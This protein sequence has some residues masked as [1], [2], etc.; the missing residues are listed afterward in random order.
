MKQ[1]VSASEISKYENEG[2][3]RTGKQTVIAGMLRTVE[4]EKDGADPFSW[5][6]E[7]NHVRNEVISK[8]SPRERKIYFA[9]DRLRR[10]GYDI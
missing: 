4:M 8:M 1:I 6:E 2:W 3:K 9:N 5:L 7:D 10:R